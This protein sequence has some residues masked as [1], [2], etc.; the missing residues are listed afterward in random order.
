MEKEKHIAYVANG[1]GGI[2]VKSGHFRDKKCIDI[3]KYYRDWEAVDLQVFAQK[4]ANGEE[5]L[6]GLKPTKKGVMLSEEQFLEVMQEAFIPEYERLMKGKL[7]FKE[8]ADDNS[9]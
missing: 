3:R 6:E 7:E 4:Q 9:G 2:I 5:A 8:V 1:E